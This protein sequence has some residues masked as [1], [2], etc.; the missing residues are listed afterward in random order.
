MKFDVD[1]GACFCEQRMLVGKSLSL[2]RPFLLTAFQNYPGVPINWVVKFR[3][4]EMEHE[5]NSKSKKSL[6]SNKVVSIYY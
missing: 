6:Q 5:S 4:G 2:N 1:R 3:F